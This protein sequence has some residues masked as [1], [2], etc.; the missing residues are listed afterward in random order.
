MQLDLLAAVAEAA[1]VTSGDGQAGA[2]CGFERVGV[3]D[4]KDIFSRGQIDTW[5]GELYAIRESHEIEVDGLAA[6]VG[7]LDK[8]SVRVERVIH[9]LA[10]S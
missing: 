8:L 4:D 1:G 2:V 3:L 5:E 9:D 6:D 10:D 7:Q